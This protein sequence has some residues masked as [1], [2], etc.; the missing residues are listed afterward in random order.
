MKLLVLHHSQPWKPQ[1]KTIEDHLMAFRRYLPDAEVHYCNVLS[2]IPF[3]V[4]QVAYDGIVLHYSLLNMRMRHP[5]WWP[6]YAQELLC[7]K[8]MSGVKI[9]IPQDEYLHTDMLW[10]LFKDIGVDTV[11]TC[12]TQAQARVLYPLDKCGVQHLFA[13]Y[14]GFVDEEMVRQVRSLEGSVAKEIDIG[15]RARKEQFLCGRLGQLKY[16]VA[17]AFL[18]HQKTTPLSMDIS[19]DPRAVF[20][21]DNWVRFLMR[22]RTVIGVPGG[23]SL[24]DIDGKARSAIEVYVKKHPTADFEEVEEHCF[25]GKDGVFVLSAISPRHFECAITR[26]CQVLVEGD[27]SGHTTMQPGV[28]Y[29]AVK[30]DFSNVLEVLEAIK[31]RKACEQ[32]AE[33]AYQDLVASGKYTYSAFVEQICSHIRSVAPSSAPAEKQLSK[34]VAFLLRLRHSG[35]FLQAARWRLWYFRAISL[36]KAWRRFTVRFNNPLEESKK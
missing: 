16:L 26:T 25:K 34:V 7:L 33:R 27:Y 1:R 36:P 14:P 4:T 29:I 24:W 23:S 19:T 30:P 22:C 11:F 5:K 12:A 10:T 2:G 18:K 31:D 20:Y 15:Y 9:A 28:H 13:T 8:K 35:K 3:Y 32:M 21:G 17:E 6:R